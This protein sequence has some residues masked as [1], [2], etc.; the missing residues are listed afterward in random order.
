MAIQNQSIEPPKDASVTTQ[1]VIE[2]GQR[3]LG[4]LDN[5][6][7]NL[8]AIECMVNQRQADYSTI[9]DAAR[10]VLA[11][12]YTLTHRSHQPKGEDEE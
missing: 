2:T 6:E 7:E 5:L 8:A 3:I 4:L 11:A 10:L 9:G 1:E 12:Y